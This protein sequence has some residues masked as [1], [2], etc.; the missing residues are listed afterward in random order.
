M[1]T[2]LVDTLATA[3]ELYR[4]DPL[5]DPEPADA[6]QSRVSSLRDS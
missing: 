3:L 6:T 4:P 1:P 2:D 5:G